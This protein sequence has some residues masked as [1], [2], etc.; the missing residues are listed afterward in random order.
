M[1]GSNGLLAQLPP[2]DITR[3]AAFTR[4]EHPPQGRILTSAADPGGEV[5]FP[6]EGAIA[7]ITTDASGRSVQTGMVGNE[8]CVGLESLFGGRR[9]VADAVIQLEGAMSVIAATDLRAV[10]QARPQI[11]LALSKFLH[12]LLT[13]S[14]QTIACN[15]LHSLLSRGCRWLLTMHYKCSTDDL[16][17]TQENLATLLGGGRPRVNLLLATLERDGMLQR[18]R[19]RIRVLTRAGLQRHACECYDLIRNDSASLLN[20]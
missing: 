15:R 10:V 17:V 20:I 7:L 9:A 1:A 4:I 8:G 13:Q 3:L 2:Q 11:Q 14:L 19:G 18:Y 5:W 16:P 12:G 6:H